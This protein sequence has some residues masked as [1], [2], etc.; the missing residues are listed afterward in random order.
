MIKGLESQKHPEDNAKLTLSSSL[1]LLYDG[2]QLRDEDTP[3]TIGL[4]DGEVIVVSSA[5]A[6]PAHDQSDPRTVVLRGSEEEERRLMSS[7]SSLIAIAVAVFSS[8]TT[9]SGCG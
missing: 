8:I 2:E 3:N 9:E 5:S 6:T 1:K 4:L 7:G